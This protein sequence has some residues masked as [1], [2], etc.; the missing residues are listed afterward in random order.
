MQ[1]NLSR[2]HNTTN[3]WTRVS[4]NQP[5]EINGKICS[6][7]EAAIAVVAITST[8]MPPRS[9]EM[10]TCFLDV[11]IEWASTWLWNSLRLVWE[12]NWLEEAI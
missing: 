12:D 5:A 1:H 2:H 9:Q 7:Q 11:L 3:H 8:A 6:V 4:T 10:P